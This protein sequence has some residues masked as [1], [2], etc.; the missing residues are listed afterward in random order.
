MKFAHV[1]G[2]GWGAGAGQ[3]NPGGGG[4]CAARAAQLAAGGCSSF[5][6]RAVGVCV[7]RRAHSLFCSLTDCTE[8]ETER[9]TPKKQQRDIM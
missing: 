8:T 3:L 6:P 9:E 1:G 4:T 7:R 5:W 2:M